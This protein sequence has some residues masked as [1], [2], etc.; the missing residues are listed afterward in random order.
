MVKLNFSALED[1]GSGSGEVALGPDCADRRL[2][3]SEHT[4]HRQPAN[5][6]R[7]LGLSSCAAAV[8]WGLRTGL[9]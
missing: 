3:L 9:L 4:V 6:L 5:I 8:A 1:A 2:V 7:R